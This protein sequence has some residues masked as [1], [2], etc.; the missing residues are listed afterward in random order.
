MY[1]AVKPHILCRICGKPL[2][3]T[4]DVV[5]DEDGKPVHECCYVSRTLS[6]DEQQADAE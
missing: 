6:S 2:N 1:T 5:A 4:S 3:L